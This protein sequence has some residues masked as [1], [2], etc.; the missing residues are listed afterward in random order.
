MPDVISYDAAE[1]QVGAKPR[2]LLL[3]NGFSASYCGY[4]NLLEKS[5]LAENAPARVLFDRLDTVNFER[6]VKAPEDASIVEAAYGHGDQSQ[7]LIADAVLVREALVNAVRVTHP[8]HRDKI[9]DVIP[10]CIE[11]LTPFSKIFTLN[12]DLLLYWVILNTKQFGDGFY[13]ATDANGYRGPFQ[14]DPRLNVYNIHGGLHLFHREDGEI[15]KR[16]AGADG[17]IDAIAQTITVSKRLPVY[18]AEGTSLAKLDRIKSVAYL[19]HCYQQLK[20]SSGHFFVFGHSADDTDAHIYSALF[21]SKITHLYFCVYD[22]GKLA[23]LDGRLSHYKKSNN[24][25]V[26]YTFVESETVG[27]WG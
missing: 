26:D 25:N 2:S 10:S 13:Y 15:E 6:V 16:L 17:I 7:A 23:E 4:K 12:Y 27:V 5:G 1:K 19:N 20:V 18:V 21:N 24:S 3:G 14:E 9:K 11:F 8:T 22:T